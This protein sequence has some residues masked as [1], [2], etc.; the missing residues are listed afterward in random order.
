MK[1]IYIIT[2]LFVCCLLLILLENSSV[3][4]AIIAA[5]GFGGIARILTISKRRP[6]CRPFMAID[7]LK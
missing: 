2:I 3:L 4:A 5:A 6:P 1:R 7:L